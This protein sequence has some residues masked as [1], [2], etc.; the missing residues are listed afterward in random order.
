MIMKR[1]MLIGMVLVFSLSVFGQETTPQKR[2]RQAPDPKARQEQM[3]NKMTEEL[4][5]TT[6]QV[7]KIKVV[8][9]KRQEAIDK[10]RAAMRQ[11]REEGVKAER[12]DQQARMEKMKAESDAYNNEIKALL[13]PEQA[14]KYDEM[15]EK[16]RERM[17]NRN[18]DSQRR[19]PNSQ[20]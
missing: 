3:L 2:E 11:S 8:M 17:Q 1:F 13:T 20:E 5:L 16:Q 19:R 4:T 6:E 14:K 10:E 12:V 9:E 15:L 18:G 7:S